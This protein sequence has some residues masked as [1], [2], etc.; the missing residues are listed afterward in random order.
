MLSTATR[1]NVQLKGER[2]AMTATD[3]DSARKGKMRKSKKGKSSESSKRASSN[4]QKMRKGER[5]KNR[6]KSAMMNTKR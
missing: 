5:R 1:T 6:S 4:E 3:A 2:R